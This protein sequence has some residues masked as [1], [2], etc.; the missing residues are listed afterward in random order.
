MTL[1]IHMNDMND[2][3]LSKSS[4]MVS[5]GDTKDSE[6]LLTQPI[7]LGVR[8]PEAFSESRT[9]RLAHCVLI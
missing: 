6:L 1:L 5:S 2:L 4:P 7:S 8:K 3:A 9:K